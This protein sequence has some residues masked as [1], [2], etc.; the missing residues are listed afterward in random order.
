MLNASEHAVATDR[1]PIDRTM[2]IGGSEVPGRTR[3]VVE[4]PATGEPVGEAPDCTRR[5]LDDA[6]DAARRAFREWRANEN[7]RRA[8]LLR[9]AEEIDA[10]AEWLA[11]LLTREQGKPLAQAREEIHAAATWCRFTA[12][13]PIPT[14]VAQ[15]DDRA[16]IEVHRRPLGVVAAITPWNYPFALAAWKVAPALLAGNTVVLKPSPFTPLCTLA[17]GELVRSILPPGVLNV[18]SGGDELGAWMTTHPAVRK[19]SFTGSVATG[20]KVARAAAEDLKRVTLELGGNDAAIILDDVDSADAAERLFWGAFVNSGQVCSAI[21]RLYVPRSRHD[22]IVDRLAERARDARIGH[23]LEP[24]TELGP[25]NNAPQ[26]DRVARLADD[27]R[28]SGGTFV[29]GGSAIEGDGYFFEPTIV[30]GLDDGA[31]LVAE[32]QF[33]PIL[34]ILAYD[35][36]DEAVE[37]AND[38]S[39]G[40]SGSVWSSRPERAAEIA[41]RLDCGTTWVN[42]H[43]VILPHVPFGG[44]ASSGIGVENGPWGLL[45]FMEIQTRH[46]SRDGSGR[47][48][49]R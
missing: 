9:I 19:I 17:L 8:L 31:A 5:E 28:R 36:A 6:M 32:E 27:A 2:V 15:D 13:L 43:M 11:T 37:R 33:G 35:D 12:E 22:E 38:T 47:S 14:E 16:R 44:L 49:E 3:F 26:L 41:A 1:D 21:K 4:D 34:P 23:G 45:E 7:Q 29:A 48:R 30:T 20:K 46:A 42:Q 40:L 39:Y 25:L 10:L 18:V 24:D